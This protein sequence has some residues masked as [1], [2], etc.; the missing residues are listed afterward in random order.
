[1][2]ATTTLA[3]PRPFDPKDILTPDELCKL[4][5]VSRGWVIEKSRRR[6][7][8]PLPCMRIGKY[9]RFHWPEV[10]AWLASTSTV[11]Q[12]RVRN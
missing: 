8:N 5:K 4:L 6:C 2:K 7:A 9:V 12:K 10:S 3:E 1:M 11:K